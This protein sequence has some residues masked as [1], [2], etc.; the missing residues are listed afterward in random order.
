MNRESPLSVK[1]RPLR[2]RSVRREVTAP[3]LE[4]YLSMRNVDF[5][6]T[7]QLEALQVRVRRGVEVLESRLARGIEKARKLSLGWAIVAGVCFGGALC[8]LH[9][10][11]FAAAAALLGISALVPLGRVI[12]DALQLRALQ[13]RYAGVVELVRTKEQLVELAEKALGEAQHLVAG[14][15]AAGQAPAGDV[16]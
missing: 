16:D 15:R 7:D 13:G 14:G 10:P 12:V 1:V 3:D 2:T 9:L 11:A 5:A 4:R 8:M 6:V